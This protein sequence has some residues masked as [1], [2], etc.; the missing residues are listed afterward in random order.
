MDVMLEATPGRASMPQA[1]RAAKAVIGLAARARAA[2]MARIRCAMA[3]FSARWSAL[4]RRF[5]K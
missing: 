2:T 3:S 5:P 4:S 1:M